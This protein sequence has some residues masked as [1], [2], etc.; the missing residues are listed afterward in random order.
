M[1][2]KYYKFIYKFKFKLVFLQNKKMSFS[3]KNPINS[4][5]YYTKKYLNSKKIKLNEGPISVKNSQM[6]NIIGFNNKVKGN[7]IRVSYFNSKLKNNRVKKNVNDKSKN[8]NQSNYYS[9]F[10]ENN[11][12][13]NNTCKNKFKKI[14]YNNSSYYLKSYQN[15]LI[16]NI[17]NDNSKNK[18]KKN[19]NLLSE[20]LQKYS[21]FSHKTTNKK[22]TINT[23]FSSNKRNNSLKNFKSILS[24]HIK[25]KR[26]LSTENLFNNSPSTSNM[27]KR[28]KHSVLR[29]DQGGGCGHISLKSNYSYI[30]TNITGRDDKHKIS[31]VDRIKRNMKNKNENIKLILLSRNN[32][33]VNNVKLLK[34]INRQKSE[35]NLKSNQTS[36]FNNSISEIAKKNNQFKVLNLGDIPKKNKYIIT[37]KN[38]KKEPELNIKEK[39]KL[40]K[41]YFQNYNKKEFIKQKSFYNL[42]TNPINS[43]NYKENINNNIII[44]KNNTSIN[45]NNKNNILSKKPAKNSLNIVDIFRIKKTNSKIIKRKK[46]NICIKNYF[47]NKTRDININNQK[48]ISK[49]RINN[50]SNNLKE[51]KNN[52][53]HN[54][55]FNENNLLNSSFNDNFD[56]LFS[57]IKKLKF[58]SNMLN[59]ESIFSTENQE[60]KNYTKK[61]NAIYNNFYAKYIIKKKPRNKNLRKSNSKIFTES[62]KMKTTSHSKKASIKNIDMLRKISEFKLD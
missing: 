28:N 24:T 12:N 37:P 52:K 11:Q 48:D 10:L 35:L 5:N 62:T 9:L 16:I 6:S 50:K 3:S 21:N 34:K 56:D 54:K 1:I 25:Q 18:N 59:T 4:P 41:K 19:I 22:I 13:N 2:T 33:C 55:L 38:I 44:Q 58:N 29:I 17:N 57:I 45:L 60:Y 32:Q 20:V 31:Y 43:N 30:N 23:N 61:F 14:S 27:R 53:I 40:K 15:P 47:S 42:S 7:M 49:K 39:N 51:V 46:S 36:F 8:E 26:I